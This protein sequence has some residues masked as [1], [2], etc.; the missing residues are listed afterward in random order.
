MP[1]PRLRGFPVP[2][3]PTGRTGRA[4]HAGDS[5]QPG[6]A[7]AAFSAAQL[8]VMPRHRPGPREEPRLAKDKGRPDR[9]PTLAKPGF[10]GGKSAASAPSPG[11]DGPARRHGPGKAAQDRHRIDRGQHPIPLPHRL[12]QAGRPGRRHSAAARPEAARRPGPAARPRLSRAGAGGARSP[13]QA[14][15]AKGADLL[16]RA[17]RH[18]GRDQPVGPEMARRGQHGPGDGAG[19]QP[20]D[21]PQPARLRLGAGRPGRTL[22]H[23]KHQPAAGHDGP[24]PARPQRPASAAPY[25]QSGREAAHEAHGSPWCRPRRPAG[26]AAGSARRRVRR[27]ASARPGPSPSRSAPSAP[28]CAAGARRSRAGAGRL[29]DA[30]PADRHGP[31]H[32]GRRHKRGRQNRWRQRTRRERRRGR[33]GP[34]GAGRSTT[35]G[36]SLAANST[37]PEKAITT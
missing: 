33:A 23:R 5:Q 15:S 4:A 35:R 12:Q 13:P 19:V 34:R 10:P 25:R 6:R 24:R 20:R 32:R 3:G 18:I 17:F 2:P 8:L 37:G 28:D 31:G 27:S 11:R 14:G 16:Q 30:D 29:F 36:V 22:R 21:R 9:H 7:A 26:R 1:K